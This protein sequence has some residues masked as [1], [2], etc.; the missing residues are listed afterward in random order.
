MDAVV[1]PK[2]R[3]KKYPQL[4]TTE[5]MFKTKR[6]KE[7]SKKRE[8]EENGTR[9]LVR[10]MFRHERDREMCNQFLLGSTAQLLTPQ[11]EARSLGPWDAKGECSCITILN[12]FHNVHNHHR[13]AQSVEHETLN[14][15]VVG[16]S[17][18]VGVLL[19]GFYGNHGFDTF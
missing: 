17:P 13:L 1:A 3:G 7:F 19:F 16:S 18:T 9:G 8:D 10:Y 6:D 5:D 15:R 2:A 4:T 12:F 14:L 11:S